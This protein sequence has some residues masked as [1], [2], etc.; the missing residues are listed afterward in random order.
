[1]SRFNLTFSGEIVAGVD[2]ERAKQRFGKMFDIDDPERIERFFSGDT[3][4]LRRGLDR[5]TA[6]QYYQDLRKIG[7][8]SELVKTSTRDTVNA[9]VDAPAATPDPAEAP[10]DQQISSRKDTPDTTPSKQAAASKPPRKKLSLRRK[11][12]NGNEPRGKAGAAGKAQQAKKTASAESARKAEQEAARRIAAEEAAR[13][14][15]EEAVAARRKAE[16]EEARR[17]AAEQ[18]ALQK[19][20]EAAE[21]LRRA[22]EAEAK[23]EAAEEAARQQAE[24]EEAK[25]R[26]A[27]EA[28]RKQA[29][30]EEAQRKATEEAA[31][32]Q[33]EEEEA[34]RKAAE[35]AARKQAKEE[36]ARH[37]AAEEAARQQAEQEQARREQAEAAARQQTE[38]AESRRVAA[39]KAAL[40]RADEA[41]QR[42]AEAEQAKRAAAEEARMRREAELEAAR[43]KTELEAARQS[44][45]TA[46]SVGQS[47]PPREAGKGPLRTSL[48]VPNRNKQ[49]LMSRKRQAGEPNLYQ[50]RAF[51]NTPAVRN[52]AGKAAASLRRNLLLAAIA[53]LGLIASVWHGERFIDDPRVSGAD[54]L[55]TQAG[56]G[57]VMLAGDQLLLHN[58]AGLGEE[59][60]GIDTL[61]LLE[62]QGPMLLTADGTLI[63]S[64]ILA[65]A[66]TAES[67]GLLRCRLAERSCAPYSD[68]LSGVAIDAMVQNPV[69]GSLLLVDATR[70]LLSKVAADG[71]LVQQSNIPVPAAPS[72]ALQ[73]GLL[74]INSTLG[75]AISVLRYDDAAFGQQLDEVLLMPPPAL[76]AKQTAVGSF[77][78]SAG[79]WWVTL[80]N[81]ASN[82]TGLYRFDDDW[83]FQQLVSS[84]E[85]PAV[86]IIPWNQKTLVNTGSDPRI[87]RY[88]SD[89]QEE[90]PLVSDLLQDL[91]DSQRQQAG[92]QQLLWRAALVTCAAAAIIALAF[93]WLNH[94][95]TLVYKSRRERGAEPLEDLS[96]S[97]LWIDPADNRQGRLR[98]R[99]LS[100]ALLAL[101]ISGIAISQSVSVLQLAALLIAM[102]GPALALVLVQR[103]TIGGIALHGQRLVL[104]DH[105]GLYHLGEG[106]QVS[107]RGHFILIDD[108]VV[109]TGN[110]LLPGFDPGQLGH[111]LRPRLA[112]AVRVDANTVMIKL[113]QAQ[114]PLAQG[115][116]AILIC[117]GAALA[118]LALQGIF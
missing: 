19:A 79:S 48:E 20:E 5:K 63:A 103:R 33:A 105:A 6:A 54:A 22:E 70:G 98:Q 107:Y 71:S 32:K 100:Y 50:L 60:F 86:T 45:T 27:E 118:I 4:T 83:N 94:L 16:E 17:I 91:V 99:T 67:P 38:E 23:R 49:P 69:D 43:L 47:A 25:R 15:A 90:V 42:K 85:Q 29:E 73:S 112:G 68:Q 65:T 87:M 117:L 8:V 37:R 101:A 115:A 88:N 72:L 75:P 28:A 58:R 11:K 77:A 104:V 62:L 46:D 116:L 84:S 89:G 30:E 39:E 110:R 52:R 9:L 93:A 96:D 106:P 109:F 2:P 13:R 34:R 55:A 108:V 21:A 102:A 114:H 78:W 35:E 113:L 24:E 97:L 95:R 1:M 36:A 61:G 57:P 26:A 76:Q 10:A 51:R 82:S 3:V 41:E 111:D 81:P 44:A 56:G 40:R 64:G 18:A 59:Q 80:F 92:L 66:N 12:N 74:F 31:R 53:L 14:N 7:L